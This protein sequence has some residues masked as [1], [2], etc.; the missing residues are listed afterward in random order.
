MYLAV[1]KSTGEVLQRA[2]IHT[3][4]ETGIIHAG[5]LHVYRFH[6]GRFQQLFVQWVGPPNPRDGKWE[7][8]WKNVE[9]GPA[10]QGWI[11]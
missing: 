10:G 5:R 9:E 6:E 3:Q 4:V 7:E 8:E 2:F 11:Y 1:R